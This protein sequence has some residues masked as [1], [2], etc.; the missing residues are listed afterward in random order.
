M[1]ILMFCTRSLN[2]LYVRIEFNAVTP[3]NSCALLFDESF[4]LMNVVSSQK[5]AWCR[6]LQDFLQMQHAQA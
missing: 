1:I 2:V 5:G 3:L 4:S 6:Y